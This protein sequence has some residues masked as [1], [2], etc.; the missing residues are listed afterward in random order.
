MPAVCLI[1]REHG[2]ESDRINSPS[3]NPSI[4][5]RAI[6]YSP[7]IALPSNRIPVWLVDNGGP[8]KEIILM[9]ITIPSLIW[10]GYPFSYIKRSPSLEQSHP[11]LIEKSCL[12]QKIKAQ[13][14]SKY[15]DIFSFEIRFFLINYLKL[16]LYLVRNGLLYLFDTKYWKANHVQWLYIHISTEMSWVRA[17]LA[18][19]LTY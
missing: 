18:S 11:E 12:H 8:S 17:D 14:H 7:S 15:V 16:Y 4:R 5:L 1:S 6:V 3:E 19:I 10:T 2:L 13:W 9:T